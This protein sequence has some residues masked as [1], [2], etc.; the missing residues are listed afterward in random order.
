MSQARG[1]PTLLE[2]MTTGTPSHHSRRMRV[3]IAGGGV[4][5]LEVLLAL[6]A[7]A[8]GLVDITLVA[9]TDTFSYRSLQVGEA[10]G[11]GHPRRY[12]LASLAEEAGARFVKAPLVSVHAGAREV[13]LGDGATLGYDALL[14]ALGARSVPAFDHGTTFGPGS[15][16]EILDDLRTNFARDV[17]I[18]VPR[19]VLWSLAAYE[20]ALMT[21]GW[22]DAGDLA[23]RVVTHEAS[24]LDI[25]GPEASDVV[26]DVLARAGVEVIAGVDADV[27]QD[28]LVRAGSHW[29]PASR[30]VSLSLPVGPR[31]HGVPSTGA[32]YLDC[33]QHGRLRSV[34]AVWAAGDCTAQP[35]KQ[36]GLASQQADAAATDI[37]RRAG[38][39]TRPRPF[40]PV[41]RGLLRTADGPL[42]LRRSLAADDG[43]GTVSPE[44]LWWPPS[45]VASRR[46][47]SH[48][49]RLDV[50]AN[51]ARRLPSGGFALTAIR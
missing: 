11:V 5:A 45:K 29:L 4:A 7:D 50:E 21:A 51:A 46:L 27:P 9:D 43:G 22:S 14:V 26:A 44:P 39:F 2:D 31:L 6:S 24:P 15:F 8:G 32:G 10:F 33:D 34:P 23:V 37:A 3:V 36:G 28:G 49:A 12:P 30:I 41:L 19:G 13:V 38:A 16:E 17:T 1:Q 47:A 35:I 42:Y 40:R 20:L 48:L 25:F 18:V